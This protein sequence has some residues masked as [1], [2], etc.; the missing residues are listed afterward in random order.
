MWMRQ[1]IASPV[2]DIVKKYNTIRSANIFK[3]FKTCLTEFKEH[4]AGPISDLKLN[5]IRNGEG[6]A[7]VYK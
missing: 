3:S 2:K 7:C 5:E 1:T 4:L 6:F